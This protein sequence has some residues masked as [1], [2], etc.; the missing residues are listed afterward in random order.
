MWLTG[1]PG[2]SVMHVVS[3]PAIGLASVT[4]HGASIRKPAYTARAREKLGY[5]RRL[6]ESW[7][8]VEPIVQEPRQANVI[9]GNRWRSVTP[10]WLADV[11]VFRVMQAVNRQ[12]SEKS[13]VI[14]HGASIEKMAYTDLTWKKHSVLKKHTGCNI[15]AGD[16]DCC[17]LIGECNAGV[18]DRRAKLDH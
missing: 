5:A 12:A 16:G 2:L 4:V 17:K 3:R 18:V 13:S 8:K 9:T 10:A 1:V 7:C 6:T 15:E 11:P 14:V